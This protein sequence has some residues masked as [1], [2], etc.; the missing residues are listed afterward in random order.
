MAIGR[1]HMC[2]LYNKLKTGGTGNRGVRLVRPLKGDN[3]SERIAS[4]PKFETKK[5][6]GI[7][8]AALIFLFFQFVLLIGFHFVIYLVGHFRLRF[9]KSL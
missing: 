8:V 2:P 7:I 5:L 9:Q 3:M 6:V 1:R 4:A